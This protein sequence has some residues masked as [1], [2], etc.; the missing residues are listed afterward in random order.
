MTLKFPKLEPWQSDVFEHIKHSYHKGQIFTVKARRQIGK[1]ILAAI[2][3]IYYATQFPGTINH[4]IEP[5]N[6]NNRNVY[7][8]MK[9]WLEPSGIVEKFNDSL[10]EIIFCNG[11]E[12]RFLSAESRD[13]LRG[14]TTTGLLVFD[15][16]AFLNDDTIQLV[17]PYV[18][19]N[20]ASMLCISTPMFKD[21]Q[22][23]RFFSNPDN[24]T[25]F[26][27]DWADEKYD[28]SKYI[29]QA[30]LDYYR[31][32]MTEFKFKT[33]MLGLFADSGGYVFSN[34]YNSIGEP[35]DKEIVSCGIDWGSGT[36][37]DFTWVTFGNKLGQVVKVIYFNDKTPTE[38]VH[39]IA[40]EINN[41]PT[42]QY[43][44]V[45]LNSIGRIYYDTLKTKLKNKSILH[46]FN[47]TN[48]SKREIIEDLVT[49]FSSGEM[50]IP[51]ISELITQ[52]LH[53]AIEKTKKG[54]TYNAIKP[55]HD[56]ACISTALMYHVV[57]KKI[58]SSYK[59]KIR[60]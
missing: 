38:Q 5:S 26:S 2:A 15:E 53:Y 29:S 19:A 23:Y 45:E 9:R 56:D 52:L 39:I 49:A 8:Q 50:L 43:I 55:Y 35:D 44:L 28:V 17:M 7:R 13:R 10:N 48:E 21:G 4:I 22:Y 32:T 46:G 24:V 40:N 14:Q 20:N 51:N 1:T 3:L 25:S 41:I 18:D 6:T 42:L 59:N 31:K 12:I 60:I 30:K 58:T 34:I 16:M 47:T 57:K 54:Y 37:N 11:S 33:E 27:F 36:G